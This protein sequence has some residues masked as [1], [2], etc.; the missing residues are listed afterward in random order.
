MTD[1]ETIDKAKASTQGIAPRHKM[2]LKEVIWRTF[3]EA[4]ER[5]LDLVRVGYAITLF[6]ALGLAAW[7]VVQGHAF[8]MT[9]FG[10]GIALILFGGGAGI[11]VRARLEDGPTNTPGT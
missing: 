1:Q 7:S 8:S 9:D 6:T 2:T 3:S 4:D 11:G 5:Y 10:T